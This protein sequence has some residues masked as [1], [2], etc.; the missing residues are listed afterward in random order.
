MTPQWLIKHPD[1]TDQPGSWVL[2]HDNWS[3]WLVFL[4]SCSSWHHYS[5]LVQKV[6]VWAKQNLDWISNLIYGNT[7]S[8]AN[9]LW[10]WFVNIPGV[11]G[12]VPSITKGIVPWFFFYNKFAFGEYIHVHSVALKVWFVKCSQIMK[13]ML[14]SRIRATINFMLWVIRATRKSMQW[15][16][17][18]QENSCYGI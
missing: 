6:Q 9:P 5:G 15:Y 16:L 18:K 4:S 7:S 13:F 11:A 2:A 14:K 17:E 10:P 1:I 12:A 3:K 8:D